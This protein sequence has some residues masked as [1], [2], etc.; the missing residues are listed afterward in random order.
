MSEFVAGLVR[1]LEQY[2]AG[3]E[4]EANEKLAEAIRLR[5]VSSILDYGEEP[6]AEVVPTELQVE[7]KVD[8]PK[9]AR[10]RKPYG[11]PTSKEEI[12]DW[13]VKHPKFSAK[14]I[15][16]A[17]DKSTAWANMIL[18]YF[19]ERKIISRTKV[20]RKIGHGWQYMY[21][22]ITPPVTPAIRSGAL[23]G[24]LMSDFTMGAGLSRSS[25]ASEPVAGTGRSSVVRA[26]NKDIN[27]LLSQVKTQGGDYKYTGGNHI[28]VT[29]GEDRVVLSNSPSDPR[30]YDNAKSQL[31]RIGF[32]F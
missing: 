3:L 4:R 6:I 28:L 32:S 25:T 7:P 22:Y 10:R 31:A 30:S 16:V 14:D 15:V 11:S 13:I 24:D 19:L 26:S 8:T 18:P 20:A 23:T 29:K 2:A 5:E 17:F 21:E 1:D 27:S 9:Q 12:R